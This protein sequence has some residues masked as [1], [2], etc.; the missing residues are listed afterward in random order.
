[1][2]PLLLLLPVQVDCVLAERQ[3]TSVTSNK[4]AAAA[5]DGGLEDEGLQYLVS[6]KELPLEQASWESAGV[7]IFLLVT[8]S[9]EILGCGWSWAP[10]WLLALVV[11]V[12]GWGGV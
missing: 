10:P 8:M 4:G 6:W 7:S 1:M 9:V 12:V 3:A 5:A 2:A 11:V